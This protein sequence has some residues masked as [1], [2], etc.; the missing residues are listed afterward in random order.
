MAFSWLSGGPHFGQI[1]RV[2]ALKKSSDYLLGIFSAYCCC[3]SRGP[4][5]FAAH[6]QLPDTLMESRE[7]KPIHMRFVI[8]SATASSPMARQLCGSPAMPFSG[9]SPI[10]VAQPVLSEI[11]EDLLCKDF[12]SQAGLS[13]QFLQ[14]RTWSDEKLLPLKFPRLPLPRMGNH[15][16]SVRTFLS[17]IKQWVP[18]ESADTLEPPK[19]S[20]FPK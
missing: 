8:A 6:I 11:E 3:C 15:V 4:G 10:A 17:G 9:C 13:W 5:S 18:C 7:G 1:L 16:S 2:L 12:C 20:K 14:R 19:P